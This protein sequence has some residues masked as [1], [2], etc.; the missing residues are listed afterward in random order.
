VEDSVFRAPGGAV[1]SAT[2]LLGIF[3]AMVGTFF[4]PDLRI[5]ILSGIPYVAVLS[6]AYLVMKSRKRASS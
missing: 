2:A 4:L 3:A 6:I 1:V 5:A